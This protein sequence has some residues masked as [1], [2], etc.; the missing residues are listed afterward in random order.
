MANQV[1]TRRKKATLAERLTPCAVCAYPITERHHFLP[2]SIYGE[3]ASTTQLCA[4]C[5]EAFHIFERAYA[6]LKMG[7]RDTQPIN[8]MIVLRDYW[9]VASQQVNILTRLIEAT[10]AQRQQ[11]ITAA[12]D[13]MVAFALEGMDE[14]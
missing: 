14:H 11:H 3:N 7:K 13:F 8:T 10:Y 1:R 6:E 9:G 5:H 2:V 4:N 12:F